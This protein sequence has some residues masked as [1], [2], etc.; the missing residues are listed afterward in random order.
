[1][2]SLANKAR[3][4]L[5]RLGKSLPFTICF[6]VLIGYSEGLIAILSKSYVLYDESYVLNTPISFY[7][8]GIFEYDLLIVFV[9]SVISVAVETCYWNKLAILYLALHLAFK[10]YIK[11]IE[12]YEETIYAICEINI[13]ISGFFVYKG[14]KILLGR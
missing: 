2:N 1:M 8:G 6:L 10:G 7:I 4:L 3:R 9:A 14:I 12:L 13:A 11:D 5:I